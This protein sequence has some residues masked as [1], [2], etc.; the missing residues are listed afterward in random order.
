MTPE[1]TQMNSLGVD[2]TQMNN[3]ELDQISELIN[4]FSD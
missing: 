3:P 2:Q 4:D 1:L